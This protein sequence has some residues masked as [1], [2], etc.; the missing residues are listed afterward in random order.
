MFEINFF[1]DSHFLKAD[2][3]NSFGKNKKECCLVAMSIVVFIEFVYIGIPG[4]F[5]IKKDVD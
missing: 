4:L 1:T 3:I 2:A 5:N